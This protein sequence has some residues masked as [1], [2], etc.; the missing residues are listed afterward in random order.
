MINNL[1]A[2][3][4]DE[5]V[6][7]TALTRKLT[8]DGVTKAY[9]VYRVRLDFLYYN[10]QNDRI[11]TW[12]S[13]YKSEH[14]RDAFEHMD[15]EAYNSI[16]ES[17]IVKSNPAAIEKTRNNIALV[18]QREPGVV[19]RDGRVIDGNRRFTCLRQLSKKSNDFNYFETVILDKDIEDNKKQIKM[20]E[21][22][23]QLGEESKVD[24]NPMERLVGV[25]QDVVESELLTI[26]EYALA[27]NESVTDVKRRIAEANL[28]IE[29]LEFIDMPKQYYIARDYQL[30]SIMP[31]IPKVLKRCETVEMQQQVKELIFTNLMMRSADDNARYIRE[32]VKMMDNGF[33]PAY[34]KEQNRIKKETKARLEE[35]K[36]DSV[37]SLRRFVD[38]NDDIT[39]ELKISRERS[40]LKS[41][42][43]EARN[44]PSQIITKSITMLRDVDTNVFEKLTDSE[45]DKL[46]TQITK[47]VTVADRFDTIVSDDNESG[48]DGLIP[49]VKKDVLDNNDVQTRDQHKHYSIASFRPDVPDIYCVDSY[50]MITNLSFKFG[51]KG[52]DPKG[53]SDSV[54]SYELFFVDKGRNVLSDKSVVEIT[55]GSVSTVMFLLDSKASSEDEIYLM[56]R[57]ADDPEDAILKKIP[58]KVEIAFTAEFGI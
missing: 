14:A 52:Y 34:L 31:E 8:I 41:K 44:K 58:F 42:R 49:A 7:K 23:I 16:I 21:L 6:Q 36:P 53:D 10:D 4:N 12:I 18:N 11:A 40:L 56:I 33:F 5:A 50:K 55:N 43:K 47:L 2:I 15:R 17:F 9:P 27:T 28:L 13:Q 37:E 19:L 57:Y 51:F 35:E 45:K 54:C 26:E 38:Q 3:E 29:F 1:L 39:D 48:S 46:K 20:L 32:I 25:Y 24:Y 22:Q 30:G